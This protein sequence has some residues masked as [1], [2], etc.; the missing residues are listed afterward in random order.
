[1]GWTGYGR[2]QGP[3]DHLQAALA[4]LATLSLPSSFSQ[5][6]FWT[7]GTLV[8]KRKKGKFR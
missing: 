2:D 5:V 1:M 4:S 3:L 8:L 6:S 7:K